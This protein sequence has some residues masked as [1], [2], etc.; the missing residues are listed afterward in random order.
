[1]LTSD[2]GFLTRVFRDQIFLFSFQNVDFLHAPTPLL[3]PPPPST[4]TPDQG[5]LAQLIASDSLQVDL[6]LSLSI[7][8]PG[9][10]ILVGLYLTRRLRRISVVQFGRRALIFGPAITSVGKLP[11]WKLFFSSADCLSPKLFP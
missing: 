3:D 5:S 7:L 11:S 1:M 8:L 2:F 9:V 4:P 10:R 6:F